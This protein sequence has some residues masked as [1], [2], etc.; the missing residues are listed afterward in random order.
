MLLL[1]TAYFGKYA[2]LPMGWIF[3]ACLVAIEAVFMSKI[4]AHAYFNSRVAFVVLISNIVSGIASVY[5]SIAING[6]RLLT[7]WFPWVSS[8]EVDTENE[9]ELFS[10]FLYCALAFIF[11]VIIELIIN[12]IFLKKRYE[13]RP[14]MRATIITNVVSFVIGSFVLY[15]Y[16]FLIFD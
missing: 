3:M 9:E 7:V 6:G 14:V 13:F 12:S 10:F 4:L 8:N 11:T 1:D 5:A 15:S 16:S 2:S